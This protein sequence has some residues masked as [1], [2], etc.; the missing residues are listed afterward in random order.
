M[1]KN[2]SVKVNSLEY[3]DDSSRPEMECGGCKQLTTGLVEGKPLCL[4]CALETLKTL[5]TPL[6]ELREFLE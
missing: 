2:L 3:T 1:G 4:D 6:S 5:M